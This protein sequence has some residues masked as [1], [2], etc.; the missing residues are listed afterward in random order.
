M[1]DLPVAIFHLSSRPDGRWLAFLYTSGGARP[2]LCVLYRLM[3]W[4]VPASTKTSRKRS[5]T[6]SFG[7]SISTWHSK[8]RGRQQ[9]RG[10]VDV[11]A[12]L[13]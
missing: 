7:S 2:G 4:S 11:G 12:E 9:N 10:F 1:L 5:L 8:R 13:W 3:C 6:D